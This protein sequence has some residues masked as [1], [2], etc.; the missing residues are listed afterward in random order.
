MENTAPP[1]TNY[2][3]AIIGAGPAGIAVVGRLLDYGISAQQILWIDPEFK[4]GDFGTRWS[5]V[6]SNTLV[7]SFLDFLYH[8]QSFNYQHCPENFEI[9]SFNPHDT[10]L[11]KYIAEPLQWVTQH[12]RKRVYSV[13]GLVEHIRLKNRT[14][15]IEV[16]QQTFLA[17]NLVLAIGAE[18]K[19]LNLPV[20]VPQLPLDI[21]LNPEKLKEQIS[22][23]DTIAVF[24]SSHSA[25]LAMKN[26]VDLRVKNVINFYRS[27]LRYAVPM[28]HWIL[29]DDTGLK[30]TAALW[31]RENING[32]WPSN[33]ER[34]LATPE[35]MAKLLP[36][37]Q[38]AIC[39]VGF[40]R[41]QKPLF[42]GFQ[43]LNY[44][45]QCGII[46]PGLFG[47]GIAFP[48]LKMNPIGLAEH[49]IGLRKF[50]EYIEQIL[51]LWLN[52]NC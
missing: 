16:H 44:I 41:R 6:P 13:L 18:A 24:G 47:F 10:C 39:A 48:E 34:A 38:K 35:N 30:G 17:K 42:Y 15:N 29:F 8:F 37:C 40:E 49:R 26:L 12:L 14:W 9:N 3:W 22:P 1:Q 23:D 52:Y 25:V 51:P 50:K 5:N 7:S 28:N 46:A 19:T 32:K 11:L 43:N 31:A 36:S 45:P 2:L 27:P 4:A 21:A 33:F 20:Q